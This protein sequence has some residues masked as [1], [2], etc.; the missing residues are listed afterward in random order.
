M[1]NKGLLVVRPFLQKPQSFP[2]LSVPGSPTSSQIHLGYGYV[3]VQKVEVRESS[4]KDVKNVISF[5]LIKPN[6]T[7]H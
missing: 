6:C 5:E 7:V 1:M 3:S 4:V 2:E